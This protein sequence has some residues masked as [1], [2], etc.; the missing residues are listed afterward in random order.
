MCFPVK[1][2]GKTIDGV[3]QKFRGFHVRVARVGYD[4]E[5]AVGYF[6]EYPESARGQDWYPQPE[7]PKDAPVSFNPAQ[8]RTFWVVLLLPLYRSRSF[9]NSNLNNWREYIIF[10][11]SWFI[12]WVLYDA[13]WFEFLLD[14]F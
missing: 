1:I 12:S 9:H 10:D 8:S 11:N 14:F 5:Q 4:Y 13:S 6:K 3:K 2:E 7:Y